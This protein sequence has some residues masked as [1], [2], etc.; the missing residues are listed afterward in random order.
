MRG[1]G[2]GM[3]DS[4][5]TMLD[6]GFKPEAGCLVHQG[7]RVETG[8][9]QKLQWVSHRLTRMRSSRVY[10]RIGYPSLPKT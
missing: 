3:T 9:L 8:S 5:T 6:V 4:K 1:S 7:N 2:C 10:G